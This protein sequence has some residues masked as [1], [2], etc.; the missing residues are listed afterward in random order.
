MRKSL[1]SKIFLMQ[2]LVAIVSIFLIIPM[3]FVFM[4]DYFL[5]SQRG[6]I[7][8]ETKRIAA[9]SEK[10]T[11][12]GDNSAVWSFYKTT[13]EYSSQDSI[14]L[15]VNSAGNIIASPTNTGSINKELINE[16]F[17]EPV[18][19]GSS[20]V[21]LYG[22]GKIFDEEMLVGMSPIMSKT[23]SPG[24]NAFLGAAIVLRPVPQIKSLQRRITNMMFFAQA[25]SW[26][27]AFI[28]STLLANQLTRPIKKM[29]NAAK[30]IAAGNFKERIPITS[31]DEIGQLAESF[32]E[33]TESLSEL[34]S[35]RTTFISDVSHELRTPMTIISGFI[36]GIIDGTIPE[37]ERNKYLGIALSE[38]KRLSRL[39]NELLEASRLEQGRVIF[40]KEN[41]DMNRMV[42]ET[43]IQY[44]QRFTEKNI[45]VNLELEEDTCIAYADKDSIKRVM[46]NLIDNAIKFTPEGGKVSF[47]TEHLEKKVRITVANTGDGIAKS[48]LKHIW[49]RFY[50]TDKSRSIDKKGVGLGLHIVRTI[51]IQNGGDIKAESEEGEFTKF[52]F[53]LNE[54][55][56]IN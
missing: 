25:I 32:N 12:I 42:T 9:L 41:I 49:E 56:K 8:K 26:L 22:Q 4:G 6:D 53:T 20:Y 55:K 21:R 40:N 52:I 46:I 16:E 15:I 37:S 19:N 14:V 18:R 35:M 23:V 29:R 5:A 39:V 33:M 45:D 34:E 38:T 48:E 30:S 36:E 27:I 1:F 7:L 28:V 31:N 17:I 50:K 3:I 47:K 10:L 43:V 51:I 13:I 24:E 44:E 11:E 2:V 54:E